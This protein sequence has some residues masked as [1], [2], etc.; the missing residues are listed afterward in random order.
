[1]C[2]SK[3]FYFFVRSLRVFLSPYSVI[4]EA[5]G[6]RLPVAP[7]WG[8]VAGFTCQVAPLPFLLLAVIASSFLTSSSRSLQ[9]GPVQVIAGAVSDFP[10]Q[11]S[12]DLGGCL[13]SRPFLHISFLKGLAA[14]PFTNIIINKK[15]KNVNPLF[16][17]FG[18]I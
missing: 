1:M 7:R 15:L 12:N 6:V 18:E 14:P 5:V 4:M 2:F 9:S 17:F 11:L 3:I 10:C 8:W 13:P 16:Y